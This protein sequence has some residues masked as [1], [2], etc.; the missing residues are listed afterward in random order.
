LCGQYLRDDRRELDGAAKFFAN[1]GET[2][3]VPQGYITLELDSGDL[4]NDPVYVVI[5]HTA[6]PYLNGYTS[7]SPGI[8][9]GGHP[10]G[11]TSQIKI[12]VCNVNL[13]SGIKS[14]IEFWIDRPQPCEGERII[15]PPITDIGEANPGGIEEKDETLSNKSTNDIS[16]HPNPTTGSFYLSCPKGVSGEVRIFDCTGRQ[17]SRKEIN[18]AGTE[19]FTSVS[20]GCISNCRK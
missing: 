1:I 8:V 7:V 6:Q 15:A 11:S 19:N 14:C 16:I 13:C 10:G 17:I 2:P 9:L 20:E 12:T 3:P 18:F 5:W 4:C